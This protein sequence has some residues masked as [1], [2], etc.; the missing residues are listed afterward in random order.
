MTFDAS[1][2]AGVARGGL[3]RDVVATVTAV[4]AWCGAFIGMRAS[5]LIWL[6]AVGVALGLACALVI[7]RPHGPLRAVA[8]LLALCA[9]TIASLASAS[10][11]RVQSAKTSTIASLAEQ[12]G[13][14][15][16]R[17]V[18]TGDVVRLRDGSGLTASTGLIEGAPRGYR[19][20]ARVESVATNGHAVQMRAPVLLLVPQTWSAIVPGTP[21]EAVLRWSP[22]R[23]VGLAG[24]GS[25][26]AGPRILGSPPGLQ[27]LAQRLR[28][29]LAQASD[30]GSGR[31]GAPL[32][33]ALVVGDTTAMS[34]ATVDDLRASGLSH[35]TAVS[36][37]NV[38]IVLGLMLALAR[39]VGV[40]GRWVL[41][42]GVVSVAFFVVL[43]R[44]EPSVLRAAVMGTIGL[45][46][47]VRGGQRRPIAALAAAVVLL[48]VL[49]PFLATELG[50]VLSV[51]ATAGLV[52]VAPWWV[53]RLEPLMPLRLAQALAIA[54]GAQ[55]MVS[56][57]I[58]AVSGRLEP[59]A[60][61]ANVLAEPAVAP[62]TVF[63]FLAALV[64]PL[65]GT[66]AHA[67]AWCAVW[68]ATWIVQVARWCAALPASTLPWPSGWWGGV[69]VAALMLA[70]AAGFI[71][72]ARRVALV[73]AALG[74]VTLVLLPSAGAAAWP[75]RDWSVI[76]CNVGQGDALLLNTGPG[77]ALLVDAGP[78]ARLLDR[79]LRDAGIRRLDAVVLTHFHVDHVQGLAGAMH[80]RS[81]GPVLVSPLFDPLQQTRLVA[82]LAAQDGS[83]ELVV[84]QGATVV[85]G[86]WRLTVLA[87]SPEASVLRTPDD[88]GSPPNNASVVMLAQRDGLRVL[89]TGD[90][91]LTAQ[92]LLVQRWPQVISGIDV[93][94]VPHHG[95]GV[96]DPKFLALAAP[97]IALISVG[98]R[99]TY[100]HPS[101]VTLRELTATGAVIGRTD[102]DGDL[103]VVGGGSAGL[104]LVRRGT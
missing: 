51:L 102:D 5:P 57:V 77:S 90:I 101:P 53:K 8:V 29:G 59:V 87:P 68:P 15:R 79:C 95:S 98:R 34:E 82:G 56:P 24:V 72:R 45:A 4:A 88:G 1:P 89:L 12:G 6:T 44:P 27:R 99:N 21:I 11:L 100:G 92:R 71:L 7:K 40:R 54:I 17:L 52:M 86:P 42:V 23:D 38:A 10:W 35:V 19:V 46:A 22:A 97:R 39:W 41:L 74:A 20:F 33:P 16:T 30:I 31:S 65:S 93:L 37:A 70:V 85:V 43:A 50:F 47:V 103:A 14:S 13:S 75:V 67:L 2:A 3:T 73:A 83:Q 26:R 63:G 36:G 58:A 91:E 64:S 94:K 55:L 69:S 104:R 48:L 66:A 49:D 84:Q 28:A 76:A 25:A 96:Q 81:V 9:L 80:A 62:A 61:M 32:V 60:L 18:T 78:D